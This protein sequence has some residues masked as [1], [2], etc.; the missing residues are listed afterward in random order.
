MV[1]ISDVFFFI[2]VE[3][4][5]YKD[6]ILN[7]FLL[8]PHVRSSGEIRNYSV[9]SSVSLSVG[10]FVR[11]SVRPSVCAYFVRSITFVFGLTL[12]YLVHGCIIMRRCVR[13]IHD[14]DTTLTFDFMVKFKGVLTCF[15]VQLKTCLILACHI[16]HTRLSL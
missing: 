4:P 15:R 8:Y 9:C 1:K 7:V 10:L 5:S 13:H 6:F 14:P 12:T 16:C 3:L 11:P 2:L